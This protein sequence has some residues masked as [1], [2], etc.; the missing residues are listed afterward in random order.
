MREAERPVGAQAAD[1]ARCRARLSPEYAA[2]QR[3]LAQSEVIAR[4]VLR[5]RAALGLTQEEL[6]AR[7]GT[8]HSAISRIESGRHKVS[9]DTLQRVADALD[10]RLLIGFESGPVR[11]RQREAAAS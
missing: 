11:H 1:S 9:V 10:A 6:A 3:R 5:R 4:L 2:E 8:S 7:V